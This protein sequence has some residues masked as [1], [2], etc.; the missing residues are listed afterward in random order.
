MKTVYLV[1]HAKSSWSDPGLSDQQRP[2][3]D[4]GLK[5][6]PEMGH[7]LAEKGVKPDLIVSSPANRARTTATII[8]NEIDYPQKQ[9]VINDRLYFDGLTAMLDIIHKTDPGLDSLM[10]VGH[11]PDMTSFLYQ[12][13]GYQ[14]NSMKTCAIATLEFDLHWPAIQFKSG[15][16]LEYDYPKKRLK[17]L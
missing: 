1:R 7:R 9:I 12:L 4:R 14:L 6:A 8:A 16:L 10:L 17:N 2:L 15:R 3:N 5:N 11:N 13:C